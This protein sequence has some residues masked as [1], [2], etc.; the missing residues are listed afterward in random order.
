[1][2]APEVLGLRMNADDGFDVKNW[3]A[4]ETLETGAISVGAS[5]W[6]Q[7][8]ARI[9]PKKRPRFKTLIGPKSEAST[10]AQRLLRV[11]CGLV[12]VPDSAANQSAK[13]FGRSP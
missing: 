7:E 4:G 5:G 1:M 6:I 10:L 8:A 9:D 3:L 13:S 12:G 11:E 2:F